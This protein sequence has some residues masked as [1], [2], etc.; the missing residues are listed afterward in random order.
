MY[1]VPMN[2]IVRAELAALR[3]WSDGSD[4]VFANPT[5]GVSITDI[6]HGFVSACKDAKVENFRFHDLRHYAELGI[7]ATLLHHGT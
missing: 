7:A 2:E 1:V 3:A 4:G 5:T 6:K